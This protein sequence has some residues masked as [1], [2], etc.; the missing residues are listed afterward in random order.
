MTKL[1]DK[2]GVAFEEM[3][4]FD[5]ELRNRNVEALGVAFWLVR[6]GVTWTEIEKGIKAWRQRNVGTTEEEG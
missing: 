5:D 4:F 3:L 6:D 1:R 2:T